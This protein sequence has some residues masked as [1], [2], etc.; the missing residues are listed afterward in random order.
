MTSCAAPLNIDIENSVLG[1]FITAF[2]CPVVSSTP[3]A[4]G[5][6]GATPF[7]TSRLVTPEPSTV[8]PFGTGLI[9][10]RAELRRRMSRQPIAA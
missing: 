7:T 4:N 8:L 3:C 5:T 10:L 2:N 1:T 6:E 9:A